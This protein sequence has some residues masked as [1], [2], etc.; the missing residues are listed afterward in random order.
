MKKNVW[1]VAFLV[2]VFLFAVTAVGAQEKKPEAMQEKA[3]KLSPK[4]IA[5]FAKEVSLF[6]QLVTFGEANKDALVMVSAVRLM[7]SL[8]FEGIAKPGKEGKDGA[9]YERIALLNQA[10]EFASGDTE[11]L[12]VITKLQD[13]PEKTDVRH[14]GHR[15]GHR[16]GNHG[17]H[18]WGHH[19][20]Y[21]GGGYYYPVRYG[22]V[23]YQVCGRHGC[24]WV[25]R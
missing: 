16:G 14:G 12:A 20:G 7:D 11:V 19:G 23:W 15:G 24:N 22:C 13:V 6:N 21:H 25:C 2:L 10:K 1:F 18:N 9:R 17:H 8:P 3:A 5:P 4:D